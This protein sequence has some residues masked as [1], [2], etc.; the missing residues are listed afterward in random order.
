MAEDALVTI[1]RMFADAVARF[2]G[3]P[4]QSHKVD[5]TFVAVTYA[6]LD[7]R[8][9]ALALALRERLGLRPGELVALVSDN[10]PAWLV[11]VLAIHSVGAVDVPRGS[12]T[13]AE[14]LKAILVHAEPSVA[15]FEDRAQVEKVVEL[16][17]GLRAAVVIDAPEAGASASEAGAGASASSVACP[18]L[19]LDELLAYGESLL[20]ARGAEV[21][22]WRAAVAPDDLASVIYTSGTTGAPKG[23]ALTH[24]NFML[25]IREVPVRLASIQERVL[26]ILPSWHAYE[27]ELEMMAL[28]QGCCIFYSSVLSLRGDLKAVRPTFFAAVPELWTTTYKGVMQ[29]IEARGPI[30]RALASWLVARS[31][32][33]AR[34]VRILAGREPAAP[35]APPARLRA[36]LVAWSWS[37]LH[38]LADRLV[39]RQI[40]ANLG[41]C[42]RQAVVGG[43]TLPDRVDEFFDAAGLSLIDGYGMTEAIVVMALREPGRG[44]LKTAGTLLPGMELRLLGRD[45]RPCPAGEPGRLFVRGPNIMRGY[46]KDEERSAAVLRPDGWFDTGDIVRQTANG[47]LRVVGRG[48]DTLV[49]ATGENVNPIRLENELAACE[50]VERAI[51]VGAGRPFLGAFIVPGRAFLVELARKLALDHGE[52]DD[53]AGHPAIVG[54]YAELVNRLTGDATR[55]APA[56]RVQRVGLWL[57]ELRVGRELSQTLRLRRH[58]FYRSYESEIAQLYAEEGSGGGRSG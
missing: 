4:V 31:L 47:S 27:R 6:E 43:G 55:F 41:G 28:S 38:A 45:G 24:G 35:A 50:G 44:V 42:L 11:C 36:R 12:D 46:Y 17:G 1:P 8:V 25:N 13:P 18:L 5:G 3:D 51:V 58:E 57:G 7:R 29:T 53:L 21:D 15:I 23:V 49:L 37:P 30:G 32:E 2:A 16:L 48:D 14:M 34:A 52:P 9:R 54:Y 33:R 10:R 26:S 39:F 22:G 20:E 56:E 19:G 40:R